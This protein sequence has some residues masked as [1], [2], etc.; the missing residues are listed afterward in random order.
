VIKYSQICYN[1]HHGDGNSQHKAHLILWKERNHFHIE[2]RTQF[3]VDIW[4]YQL[5][6]KYGLNIIYMIFYGLMGLKCFNFP[7]KHVQSLM[8]QA[9]VRLWVQKTLFKYFSESSTRNAYKKTHVKSDVT[10]E[11]EVRY[12]VETKAVKNRLLHRLA[13]MDRLFVL[14]WESL[15]FDF[16]SDSMLLKDQPPQL[17]SRVNKL[18]AGQ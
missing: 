3:G 7:D 17:V 2:N 8:G 1:Y 5:G 12:E 13:Q 9:E 14:V 16:I 11:R 15:C 6:N 10:Y 4:N 18:L